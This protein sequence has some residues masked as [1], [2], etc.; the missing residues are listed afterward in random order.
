MESTGKQ[1][2]RGCYPENMLLSARASRAVQN[3][4]D[5]KDFRVIK[6]PNKSLHFSQATGIIL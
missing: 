6:S 5:S 1:T 3:S 2:G 4:L